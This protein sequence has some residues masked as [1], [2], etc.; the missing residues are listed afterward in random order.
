M[1]RIRIM[2]KDTRD[3]S[4][5]L[6]LL[7]QS[8]GVPRTLEV[9]AAQIRADAVY[10]AKWTGPSAAAEALAGEAHRIVAEAA[11]ELADPGPG[12]RHPARRKSGKR[13]LTMGRAA[14]W[15]VG[16]LTGF[17]LGLGVSVWAG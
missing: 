11:A 16:I 12:S 7:E 9:A 5:S 17:T 13:L 10:L 4:N 6:V 1:T 3:A 2:P 8:Q 15:S 14:G